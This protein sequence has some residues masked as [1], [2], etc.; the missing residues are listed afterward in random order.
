[1]IA[2]TDETTS[3]PELDEMIRYAEAELTAAIQEVED[4]ANQLKNT[5]NALNTA[6]RD[7]EHNPRGLRAAQTELVAAVQAVEEASTRLRDAQD[8]LD[9][10]NDPRNR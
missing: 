7:L 1:M 3:N 8:E 9:F 10:L 6:I 4:A 5:Q 2:L